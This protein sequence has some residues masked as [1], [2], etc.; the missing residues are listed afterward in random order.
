VTAA[1]TALLLGASPAHAQDISI[2]F[3]QGNGTGLTE[4]VFQL[5]ALL[6]VLSLAP[7]IL[8]MMTLVHPDRGGAVAVAH[9][10][11]HR[12]RA[13]QCGD[14]FARFVSH[15]VRHGAGV[16]RSYDLGIR[17]LMANEINA[18][19][20]FERSSGP[21][22]AFMVKNVRDKDLKLNDLAREPL[23][24]EPEQMS[25]RILIPAFMVSELKRAFEIGFCCSLLSLYFQNLC[26]DEQTIRK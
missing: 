4:R 5:I 7:S 10:A 12:D 25:L 16:P 17:P 23:P 14:H 3:G 6:T 26:L 20:A 22:K 8:V 18:E 21:L 15:R 24:A 11:R 9:R 19:Q 1:A 13:A 2:S